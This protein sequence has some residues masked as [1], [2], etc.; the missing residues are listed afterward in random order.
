[1]VIGEDAI[2]PS[3]GAP[4]LRTIIVRSM[5]SSACA[6]PD[7]I[8]RMSHCTV[9]RGVHPGAGCARMGAPIAAGTDASGSA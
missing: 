5:L 4:N 7:A 1:M 3:A 2:A 8:M 6:D 9:P